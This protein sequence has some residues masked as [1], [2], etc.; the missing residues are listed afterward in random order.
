[1]FAFG[2]A[3]GIPILTAVALSGMLIDLRGSRAFVRWVERVVGALMLAAG[4]YL[5]YLAA[6]YAGWVPP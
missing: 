1:M 2:I 3:R 6:V 4:A 5:L